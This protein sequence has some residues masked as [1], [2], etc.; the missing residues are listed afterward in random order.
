MKRQVLALAVTILVLSLASSALAN[1]RHNCDGLPSASQLH[2]YL[3]AAATGT[4]VSGLLGPGT[5]AGGLFGGTRMWGAIVNR[6]GKLC[7]SVTSTADPTQVWPGSQAIAKAKAYTAN[8]FS[9]DPLALSTARLYLFV[10]PGHSLYG[11]NNSNPFDPQF[12]APPAGEGGQKGQIGGGVITFGGGVP[13]YNAAGSIIGGL[14]VSGDTACADHEV[15]KRARDLAGLNPPGGPLADDI[16]Y[17]IADSPPPS[18]FGH[19]VCLGTLRNGVPIGDET[20][21]P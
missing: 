14:G 18:V 13:L 7:V 19:P 21:A 3:V 17:T 1:N 8:A 12:L 15:A 10:Q 6:D 9:V 16:V 2:S 20:P 11:L 4:G 5:S